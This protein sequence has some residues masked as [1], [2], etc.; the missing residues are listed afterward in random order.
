MKILFEERSR[1]EDLIEMY[2]PQMGLPIGK[3]ICI[4]LYLYYFS[5]WFTDPSEHLQSLALEV[6]VYSVY[7]AYILCGKR[8]VLL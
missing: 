1:W 5:C 8:V 4:I 3:D 6:S 7:N 2:G